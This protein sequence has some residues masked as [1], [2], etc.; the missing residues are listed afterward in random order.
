[1]STT[2]RDKDW[3]AA[4]ELLLIDQ[5]ITALMHASKYLCNE[6]L[7]ANL[8]LWKLRPKIHK[9]W[10]A[11]TNT[12]RS[13]RPPSCVWS[14]KEEECMGKLARIACSVH[15]SVLSQRSLQRWAV[16]FFNEYQ[17]G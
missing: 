14:F 12:Q 11:N 16:Q 10:H 7:A 1:M 9:M 3:L 8:P 15:G 17:Q 6:A 4:D 2:P 5:T 13:Q